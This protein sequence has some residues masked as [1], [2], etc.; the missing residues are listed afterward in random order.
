MLLGSLLALCACGSGEDR[1][2]IALE[3]EQLDDGPP[4]DGIT[5]LFF[6]PADGF[7]ESS[8]MTLPESQGPFEI[9]DLYGRESQRPIWVI[10]YAG[11]DGEPLYVVDTDADLDF[12]EEASLTFRTPRQGT[13][14]AD[15]RVAV[16]ALRP[17]S[18]PGGGPDAAGSVPVA[19]GRDDRRATTSGDSILYQVVTTD[20][21]WVYGRVAE[22]RR[23]M[24]ELPGGT[25]SVVIHARSRNHPFLSPD[26]R[27][28]VFIDLDRDG[29][30]DRRASISRDGDRV[31]SEEVSIGTPFRVGERAFS[32][33]EVD[34]MGT[35]LVL[36]P[37]DAATAPSVGFRAPEFTARDLDGV[38]RTLPD[39]RADDVVLLEF[40]SVSCPYCEQAR[41]ELNGLAAELSDAPFEWVIL[42]RER[43]PAE[44]VAFLDEHPT[45]ASVLFADSATWATYNPDLITPLFYLLDRQGVIQLHERGAGVVEAIGDRASELAGPS[46]GR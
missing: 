11:S 14:V 19:G 46:S 7:P 31:A 6:E 42:P 44:V 41:P 20:E 34:S 24:V 26:S 12:A 21:G 38:R 43:D 29:R 32:I 22:Y 8:R 1:I 16:E 37:S 25:T 27:P 40:W 18:S 4:L 2:S 13:R 17:V 10:R 23:G 28:R 39:L 36:A 15:V 30:V 9:A 5:N 33:A 3:R 45:N 35:R